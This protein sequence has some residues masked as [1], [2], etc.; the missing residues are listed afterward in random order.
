[1]ART[2]DPDLDNVHVNRD[3]RIHWDGELI[4]HVTKVDPA[5][6]A[7]GAWRAEIGDPAKP[8]A[9][10]PYRVMYSRTRT[11]AVAGVLDGVEVPA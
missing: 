1:M 2:Y 7:M 5:Y 6:R 4:G 10:P 11:D 3:G 8:E 9:W